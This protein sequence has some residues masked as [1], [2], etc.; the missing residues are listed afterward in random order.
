M[1]H[2]RDKSSELGGGHGRRRAPTRAVDVGRLLVNNV[3]A[4]AWQRA[5]TRDE[6]R[7]PALSSSRARRSRGQL[8]GTR[9]PDQ[10]SKLKNV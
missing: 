10:Q 9:S 3:P 2:Q 1:A 6:G 4:R 7:R 8:V 5:P